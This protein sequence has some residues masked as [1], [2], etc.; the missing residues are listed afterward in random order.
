M[1]IVASAVA[2]AASACA[3]LWSMQSLFAQNYPVKPVRLIVPWTPGGTADILARLMGQRLTE[4]F[5]QQ[6]IVDNRPGASGQIGTDLVA[7]APPDGYMLVLGTTAPNSTAPSLYP[8]LPYDAR[9]DF[10]PISLIALTFYVLSV[11]P[12]VPVKSVQELVKLA[13]ARPGELNFSSPGNGTPNHLSGEM[14]KIRAGIQMQHI[15]FKG[16]A[17]AIADVIGGQIPLNFE[18]IAVV[19]PHIK[20]GKVRALG[21]TSA[22]RS[23]FLPET[24]TIAESGYPGFEAVGWFG[25]MG[26]AQTPRDVLARLNAETVRI[27]NNPEVNARIVG[28]GAQVRPTSMAEF[29]TFNRE[30][31]AKWAKVIKD[32][33]AQAD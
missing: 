5:G 10:A 15:P 24:P 4:S 11:N 25:L 33:G 31:I 20:A 7:K 14:L 17:Q 12:H 32:S 8:R 19:L 13:K 27:L 6:V 30:Q 3:G 21:V 18:N 29:E 22:Q 1:R 16:S 2:L 28:L 23:P 26:P 9:K